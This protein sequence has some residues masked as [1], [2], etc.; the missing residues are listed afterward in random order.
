MNKKFF[1]C[2]ENEADGGKHT[3][4]LPPVLPPLELHRVGESGSAAPHR[5]LY[6]DEGDEEAGLERKTSGCDGLRAG[7]DSRGKAGLRGEEWR[8]EAGD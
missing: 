6:G 5:R 7:M 4:A 3:E 8:K 2:A 1:T